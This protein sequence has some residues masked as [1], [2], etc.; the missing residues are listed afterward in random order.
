[1]LTIK[2]HLDIIHKFGVYNDVILLDMNNTCTINLIPIT[3]GDNRLLAGIKNI[4]GLPG[5][6]TNDTDLFETI[7][8]AKR[9]LYP[10]SFEKN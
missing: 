5:L 3:E 6:V 2:D 9:F 8:S 7:D 10:Y 1:M 4:C